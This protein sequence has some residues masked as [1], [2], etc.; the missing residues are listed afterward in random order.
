[1]EA[2]FFDNVG[3]NTCCSIYFE[4]SWTREVARFCCILGEYLM[5]RLFGCRS[6]MNH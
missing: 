2:F 6:T 1:M 4:S 5:R 3:Y